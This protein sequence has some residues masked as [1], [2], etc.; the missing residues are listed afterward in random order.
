MHDDTRRRHSEDFG[1]V[2]RLEDFARASTMLFDQRGYGCASLSAWCLLE[3]SWPER[4][5]H[6]AASENSGAS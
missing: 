4:T 1:D 5:L 3:S 6:S 2:W